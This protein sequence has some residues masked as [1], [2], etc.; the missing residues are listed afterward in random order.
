M[1]L[2]RNVAQLGSIRDSMHKTL[3]LFNMTLKQAEQ[4][5]QTRTQKL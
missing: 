5:E 3:L 2:A 4:G 1:Q